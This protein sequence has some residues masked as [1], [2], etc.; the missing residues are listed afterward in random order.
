MRKLNLSVKRGAD[1]I[2]SFICLLILSP[3]FLIVAALI[4]ISSDGTVFFMQDRLGL[5]GKTFKII[6]FRTMIMGAENKGDGLFVYGSEDDRITTVGKF[7]RKTSLDEIPQLINIIKGDMSLVG[8]RP[9][10]TYY[11]YNGYD[12]YPDWAKKRFLMRPGITGLAQVRTRTSAPWDERIAIDNEY[13]D[14]FNL[15]FD[16]MILLK[17]VVMVVKGQNIYPE[18][19]ETIDNDKGKGE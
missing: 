18:S 14:R 15:A 4:K 2:S 7:L 10:V 3:L 11:P 19:K 5:N 8:P 17:T 9:P 13:V 1:I 12:N 16:L 6:K